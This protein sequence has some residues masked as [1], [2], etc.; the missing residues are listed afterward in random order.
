MKIAIDISPTQSAHNV[1]GTGSYTRLLVSALQKYESRYSYHLFTRGQNVPVDTDI[2]HYP[3]F[4]PFFLTLPVKKIK[5]TIVT[6]HDLI[7]IAYPEHFKKGL[8][9]NIKWQI[10]RLAL[11][12]VNQVITDSKASKSDI[13]KF[14][15]IPDDKI[16]VIYL[17]PD[18]I[19]RPIKEASLRLAVA[20][21]YRLPDKFFLYVGDINWNKNIVGLLRAFSEY[22]LLSNDKTI[23]LFLI[24]KAFL[25]NTLAEAIEINQTIARLHLENRVVKLGFVPDRDLPVI[26]NLASV[27]VQPSRAEG[28]GLPVLEAM[29]SGCPV[30]SSQ[31]TSLKEI[32]GPSIP[33]DI[34]DSQST[35]MALK[36][37]L[38]LNLKEWR[39]KAFDWVKQFSWK[40]VAKQTAAV[41]AKIISEH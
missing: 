39:Q 31:A 18:D 16:H 8:R 25:D 1:R 30:V 6:V 19:F 29:A 33:A 28:F 26:Y 14:T 10:Q 4:D 5:P 2:I 34:N 13:A 36:T 20:D 22:I 3:Y 9:G 11:S 17:A 32:A 24:G 12:G 40:Y 7:P 15:S 23:S 38:D 41:Y 27:Y 35:A 21:K 37:A